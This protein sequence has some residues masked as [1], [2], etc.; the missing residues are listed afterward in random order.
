M[1]AFL[2]F[3]EKFSFIKKYYPLYI[4]GTLSTI[5]ICI[6]TII[7]GTIIGIILAMMKIS[8]I[9]FFRYIANAYIEITRGSPVLVQ[10]LIWYTF[11]SPLFKGL[12]NIYIYEMELKRLLPGAFALSLNSG[13]YVAEIIRSGISALDKG[14]TEAA[15]SLGMKNKMVLR[16]IIMPQAIKNVLPALGNEFIVLIK[17]SSILYAIGIQELMTKTYAIQGASL[18][19]LHPLLVTAAIYF[20]LTFT[21]SRILARFERRLNK[22]DRN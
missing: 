20:V 6:I 7:L 4:S 9:K 2:D 14:Q 17:E 15:L 8:K 1:E 10:V 19:P 11:L 22:N 3:F 21:L 18:I 16:Y 13:A 12:S 5:I